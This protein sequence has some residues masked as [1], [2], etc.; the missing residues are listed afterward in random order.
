L[1]LGDVNDLV[2]HELHAKRRLW[3]D[4][5]MFKITTKCDNVTW[6]RIKSLAVRP[7]GLARIQRWLLSG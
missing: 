4:A 1:P 3:A 2:C 6:A 7:T 5:L